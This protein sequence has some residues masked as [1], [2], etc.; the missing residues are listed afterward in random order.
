MTPAKHQYSILKQICQHIPAH[1]VSK[2]SRSFGIDKQSRTF[3]CWSHIVSMLHVQIAHSLSL[4]DVSDTLRNHSGALTPIRRATPS[5]R[6]GLSHA[7]RVRDPLM[8]ETLFWEVLSHIQNKHLD[9]GRGHKYSGLPRRF[10]RAI[11]AVDSTTIQLVANCIDW[12]KHRRRK[13]A[14]KCHM[15]LNLQTFLPQFAIVKEASTHDS[16]E[17][18]QLCQDLKSG[19][20]AVFDKAY[21]DFKHLADLDRRELFWV[22][23]AKDNMKYRFVKQNTEPK[24]NIQYDAL[25][26]LEMPKSR[27]A[28][29]KKLR[30]VKAYVEINGEKKLMKFITNNMQWAPSS[31]CDLYKCRWGIEVFFKQI[32]QTLQLSDFLGHSQKAILWQVWTAMLAYILIRYIG[33]LGQWK[34]AFS[35]LFT[36]LRGYYSAGWMF[37]ALWLPVGQHVVHRVWLAALSRLIC[38]VLIC[39]KILRK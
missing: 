39:S 3:S 11:Y 33:F 37:L 32:K 18:Y 27:E 35:R 29:P 20:I 28:Y 23:R 4:N 14:A 15:Q 16:T 8:A 24:G 34:G 10:K 13:A 6:N 2:L 17:A 31:I 1:L 21:V 26:E 12:A 19:E 25:I 9:F 22:T 38:R 36:L 5:S 7:N 30:L